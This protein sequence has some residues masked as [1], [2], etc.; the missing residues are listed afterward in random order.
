MAAE[1]EL[2]GTAGREVVLRDKLQADPPPVDFLL[3]DCPPSLGLLTISALAAVGE[4][5]IPLQPHF[6]ALHGLSKLLETIE[7]VAGCASTARC[8]SLAWSCACTTPARGWPRKLAKTWSRF[9]RNG[10]ARPTPWA[11]AKLF[12]SRVRR[13]IRLAEAPGF[14]QSIFQYAADSHGAEDYRRLAEEIGRGDGAEGE[15]G[16]RGE[17]ETGR[18]GNCAA[19]RDLCVS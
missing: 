18:E 5:V 12:E 6:F 17:G 19:N 11:E 1:V 10:R 16:R 13:N 15:R 2:V 4:V 3:V 8:G 9:L 7:A 14:G